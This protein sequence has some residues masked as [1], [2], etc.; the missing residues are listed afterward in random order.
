MGY[1]IA[2]HVPLAGLAMVPIISGYDEI[3]YPS[4]IVFLELLIDPA[5][6]VV[7]EAEKEEPDVMER[8]PRDIN[9]HMVGIENTLISFGQGLSLFASAFL[10]YWVAY[11]RFDRSTEVCSLFLL[12]E[13]LAFDLFRFFFSRMR[14]PCALLCLSLG[15]SPSSSQTVRV[16]F[17][18]ALSS[19]GGTYP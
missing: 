4:H 3:L 15:I 18:S 14:V 16:F 5:C 6:S 8:P 10:A 7:L 1:I 13:L 11:F 12:K 17:G 19:S 9:S 2:I